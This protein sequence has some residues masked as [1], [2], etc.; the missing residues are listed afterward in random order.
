MP[1][2]F[3]K[4][5]FSFLVYPQVVI[6]LVTVLLQGLLNISISNINE[7]GNIQTFNNRGTSDVTVRINDVSI[8]TFSCRKDLSC[9]SGATIKALHSAAME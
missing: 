4:K 8:E 6:R 7:K 5:S 9:S 2:Y 1:G 3:L